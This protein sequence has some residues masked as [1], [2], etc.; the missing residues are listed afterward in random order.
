MSADLT[1]SSSIHQELADYKAPEG[2]VCLQKFATVLAVA[3]GADPELVSRGGGHVER[4]PLPSPPPP[5]PPLPPSFPSRPSPPLPILPFPPSLPFPLYLFPSLPSPPL[6]E[7][8]PRV[9]SGKF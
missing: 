9:L 8:G 1:A 7:G 3:A 4:P 5:I 6:E 2:A